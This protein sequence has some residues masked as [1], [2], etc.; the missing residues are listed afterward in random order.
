MTAP[1]YTIEERTVVLPV[2]IRDASAVYASFLVPAA[3]VKRLL[4]PGLTPLQTIPGR[5]TCTIVGVDYKDGDLGKYHE[6]GVCFLLRPKGGPRLDL[7]AMLRNRAP[8]YIHRLPVTTSFSCEAGRH[9]WGFPKDV[10]DIEFAD[11]D[12]T[13]TVTLRDGGRLVLQLTAP[14]GGTKRFAGVDIEAMGSWGGAVQ[15]TPAHMGGDGVQAGF[16]KGQLVLGDH[17]IADEL[18]SM[19]LPKKPLVAG[20]IDRFTGSFG[21]ARLL[22]ERR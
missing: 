8:A 15:V 5:A 21:E 17:P 7:L 11:D 12:T 6:V 14:R 10:M 2:Q 16:R 22:D 3:A 4:P 13:R 1:V 9:I 18:R 20:A 19:G